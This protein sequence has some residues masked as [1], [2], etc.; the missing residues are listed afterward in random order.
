MDDPSNFM[1]SVRASPW[2]DGVMNSLRTAYGPNP[3]DILIGAAT[4]F[5]HAIE[6]DYITVD[7]AHQ[8]LAGGLETTTEL[9]Q[10]VVV[11][12]E[13]QVKM[14]NDEVPEGYVDITEDVRNNLLEGGEPGLAWAI[15]SVLYSPSLV[16]DVTGTDDP[17]TFGVIIA[18]PKWVDE[19]K[20]PGDL[21]RKV[22]IA[23]YSAV[24]RQEEGG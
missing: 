2:Y 5:A 10:K 3:P 21:Q 23:L 4:A 20:I 22:S 18:F 19:T 1:D 15:V 17:D 6:H 14:A 24:Q 8:A 12:R 11:A 13:V 16:S 9:M 7:E